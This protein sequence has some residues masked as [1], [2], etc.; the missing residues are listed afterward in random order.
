VNSMA[1]KLTQR[2]LRWRSG[3]ILRALDGGEEFVITR[4]GRAIGELR[5]YGRRQ[6]VST[7][8]LIAAAKNLP[9]I[10]YE[11]LRADLDRYVDQDPTPRFWVD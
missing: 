3:R 1:R 8:Q 5:P 7:D 10:D 2:E 6:F 4:R 11:E 9:S